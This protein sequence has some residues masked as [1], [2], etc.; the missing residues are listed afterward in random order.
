[1]CIC[2]CLGISPFAGATYTLYVAQTIHLQAIGDTKG[3]ST[4]KEKS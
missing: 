4:P 2:S 1:M 3:I